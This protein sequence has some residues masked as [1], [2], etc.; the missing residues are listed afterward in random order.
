MTHPIAAINPNATA[1]AMIDVR[2]TGMNV[3][4]SYGRPAQC[5]SYSTLI[6]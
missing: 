6:E 4:S 2:K 5:F 1:A 3:A